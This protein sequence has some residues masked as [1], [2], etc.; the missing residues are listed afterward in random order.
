MDTTSDKPSRRDFLRRSGLSAVALS[1]TPPY[2]LDP[3]ALER[4]ITR[5]LDEVDVRLRVNGQDLSTRLEPRVPLLDALREH[6]GLTGTKK[7]CGHGH[8]GACTV[9][10]DGERVLS[11]LTLAVAAQGKEL[12]TIEG[13]AS[14]DGSLHPVQEAMIRHDGFQ[15]GYCTSGQIMSGIACIREGHTG[16][17][18]EIK[19]WMSG[20][21]CRCGAYS[22]IVD[23][24]EE[25]NEQTR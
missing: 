2:T 14:A 19:E 12:T 22:N 5:T 23:A 17:R 15:C 16:S 8:C 1:V 20:N 3:A 21:L 9:H 18:S 4:T 25:V 24:I 13:I 6:L 10:L 11:C 7:G